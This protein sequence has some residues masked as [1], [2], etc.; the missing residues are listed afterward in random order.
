M[1]V[2][3]G[4][5]VVVLDEGEPRRDQRGQAVIHHRQMQA[6]KV[7]DVAADVERQDLTLSVRRRLI[8]AGEALDDQAALRRNIALAHD[9]PIGREAG[10]PQRQVQQGGLLLRR[11]PG[12]ALQ[13]ADQR[14][15]V[16]SRSFQDS[17]PCG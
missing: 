3:E 12:D 10:E 2:H 8:T 4:A 15:V 16:G 5:Q 1:L 14:E 7:G 17:L 6:L 9:V 11:E 13:L